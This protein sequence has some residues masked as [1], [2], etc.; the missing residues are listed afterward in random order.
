MKKNL[1]IELQLKVL[2][3]VK[4]NFNMN[5][6]SNILIDL[7]YYSKLSNFQEVKGN[8]TNYDA[9]FDYLKLV[10]SEGNL[11]V[12]RDTYERAVAN[13]PPSN[14]CSLN[15]HIYCIL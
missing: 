7:K 15:Y 13:I 10:E 12:I 6:Y 2:L 5:K 8:P 11:E 9:W 14:V 1:E 3:V 4:E